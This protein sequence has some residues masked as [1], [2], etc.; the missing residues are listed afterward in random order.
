MSAATAFLIYLWH[1]IVARAIYD[2]VVRPL[3]HGHAAGAV[4]FVCVAVLAFALG[5][6]TRSRA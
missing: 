1:Y 6:V 3:V 2:H 5:R 4:A